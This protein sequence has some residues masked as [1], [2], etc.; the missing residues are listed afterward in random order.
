MKRINLKLIALLFVT[1]FTVNSF[2]QSIELIPY[3]SW[4]YG[5]NL[6]LRYGEAKV[7]ASEN[8]GGALNVVM[9][10]GVA[11]QLEYFQQPTTLEYREYGVGATMVKYPT[12]IDWYQISGLKQVNVSEVVAPYG[13]LSLG[14]TNI[15]VDEPGTSVDEWAFSLTGQ[16]GV[17]LYVSERV[18]IRLHAR[19]L[20]PVQWGGFGFYFG[21]GGS[22]TSV[23]V[24]SYIVQGDIGGGLIIRLGN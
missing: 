7:K 10:T 13:G 18:G 21:S 17:K 1:F 8:F 12:K 2:T 9:P 11:L 3:A 16:I 5:G 14:A 4:H 23:N 22:G 19:M 20:M 24:G 15:R 6:K